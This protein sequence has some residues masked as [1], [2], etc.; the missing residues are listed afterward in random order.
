LHK[1][2]KSIKFASVIKADSHQVYLW[3]FHWIVQ[4]AICIT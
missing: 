2:V 4:K 3:W 1:Y